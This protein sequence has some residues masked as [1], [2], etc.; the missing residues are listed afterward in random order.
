MESI[1]IQKLK[2]RLQDWLC[3]SHYTENTVRGYISEFSQL[4]VFMQEQGFNEYSV[5]IG[6]L[7]QSQREKSSFKSR[8]KTK[9][10][11]SVFIWNLL[12]DIS[13]IPKRRCDTK[14]WKP[15]PVSFMP[16]VQSYMDDSKA[17]C[18]KRSTLEEKERICS[19]FFNFLFDLGCDECSQME[20]GIVL[21]AILMSKSSWWSIIKRILSHMYYEG[22]TMLDF[23][24]LVPKNHVVLKIPDVYT[25]EEIEIAE[26]S[27][28]RNTSIGKRNFAIFKIASQEA[29]RSL[30]IAVLKIGSINFDNN[31]LKI[32]Q[33]KTNEELELPLYPDVKDAILDYLENGRPINDSAY[34]FLRE[35]APYEH[36]SRQNIYTII[37]E[38]ITAAGISVEGKRKGGHSLRASNATH[39]V[40]SGMRYV[41][42]QKSLGH[43]GRESLK[44]YA[45]QDINNLRKCAMVPPPV[46]KESAFGRFLRGQMV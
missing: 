13:D 4:E 8:T 16:V 7:Y 30:D 34:V 14:K 42:I 22:F 10:V 41:D 25:K 1:P 3:R 15:I 27:I 11:R 19:Y 38:I 36:L 9:I 37:S 18:N 2:Y 46:D 20:A 5:E 44:H 23:S 29:L 40:N 26:N 6:G 35:R 12:L 21:K 43:S 45:V 39:K 31:H 33:T 32:V 24:G 28:D 17:R